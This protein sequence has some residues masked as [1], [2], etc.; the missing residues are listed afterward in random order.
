MFAS[1]KKCI[2]LHAN[3]KRMKKKMASVLT[4]ASVA[5]ALAVNA[6]IAQSSGRNV[7]KIKT[8]RVV[9][10]CRQCPGQPHLCYDCFP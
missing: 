5:T 1:F 7:A 9:T 10:Q 8:R 6:R 3:S 2:F 4:D